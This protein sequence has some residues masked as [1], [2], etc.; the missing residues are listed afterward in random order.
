MAGHCH[1]TVAEKSYM[2]PL[3]LR[4][5][6]VAL[7]SLLVWPGW[8]PGE[9]SS[10][11]NPKGDGLTITDSGKPAEFA[12]SDED[13][14][15]EVA[16]IDYADWSE[17]LENNRI[18]YVFQ[19][20]EEYPYYRRVDNA[21]LGIE[22]K[23]Y[24]PGSIVP[25]RSYWRIVDGRKGVGAEGHYSLIQDIRGEAN[26]LGVAV[27]V[28]V[29]DEFAFFFYDRNSYTDHTHYAHA[30]KGGQLGVMTTMG[31]KAEFIDVGRAKS[32]R[33]GS[34]TT[35]RLWSSRFLD[36]EGDWSDGIYN[37]KFFRTLFILRDKV[38]V[39]GVERQLTKICRLKWSP[40]AVTNSEKLIPAIEEEL[41]RRADRVH[42]LRIVNNEVPS[43][44]EDWRSAFLSLSPET[45]I[46]VLTVPK[47]HSG[48]FRKST[49]VG[50]IAVTF[51]RDP[52]S[53][54]IRYEQEKKWSSDG[55]QYHT[56]LYR[57]FVQGRLSVDGRDLGWIMEAY[58]GIYRR[59]CSE[60][61]RRLRDQDFTMYWKNVERDDFRMICGDDACNVYIRK[62][63]LR[64]RD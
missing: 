37:N 35:L 21:F 23:R 36:R 3:I 38:E 9:E 22:T 44:R 14:Y 48:D 45:F 15:Q 28:N 61:N 19:H 4:L 60:D 34:N 54:Q 1:D 58:M 6:R 31:D 2:K 47:G 56:G 63:V 26:V 30:A 25:N 62:E 18:R 32:W 17:R 50:E 46:H 5:N 42:A 16:S 8:A 43:E 24:F 49:E 20:T 64:L 33:L 7:I 29:G 39:A 51:T 53:D 52:Y 40:V 13:C 57:F 55:S 27:N 11:E 59:C 41:M 12:L 10:P